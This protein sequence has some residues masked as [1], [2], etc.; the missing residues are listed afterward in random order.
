[1]GG[2]MPLSVLIFYFNFLKMENYKLKDMKKADLVLLLQSYNM[3]HEISNVA[4]MRAVFAR[5]LDVQGFPR[6]GRNY[7][8]LM[9]PET[10]A[11]IVKGHTTIPMKERI[12]KAQLLRSKAQ[13]LIMSAGCFEIPKKARKR[14][15]REA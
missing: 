10:H 4:N 12:K 11:E 15:E 9:N 5:Y 2:K 7:V 13:L 3:E 6:A 8:N 1:M 14:H